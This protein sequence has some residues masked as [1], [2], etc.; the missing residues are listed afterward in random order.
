[1]RVWPLKTRFIQPSAL[2]LSQRNSMT[3]RSLTVKLSR[4]QHLSHSL[5]PSLNN[6]D[7][8]LFT[9]E[10]VGAC[11]LRGSYPSLP[12][13]TPLTTVRPHYFSRACRLPGFVQTL[14]CTQQ[15]TGTA[16]AGG[17]G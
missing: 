12:M 2:F 13:A 15:H 9:R 8:V 10:P 6:G 14:V 4:E 16:S 17:T 5:H 11:F 1:M 7:Q 3:K